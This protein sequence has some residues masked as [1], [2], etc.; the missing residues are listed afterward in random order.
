VNN[1][2]GKLTGLLRFVFLDPKSPKGG[3]SLQLHQGG[4]EWGHPQII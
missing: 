2:A 4:G 3:A 1:L